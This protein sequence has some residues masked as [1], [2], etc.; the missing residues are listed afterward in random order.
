MDDIFVTGLQNIFG[1]CACIRKQKRTTGWCHYTQ[2]CLEK[3][4]L[5][6]SSEQVCDIHVHY[7]TF[8][9]VIDLF[10]AWDKENSMTCARIWTEDL[11][12]I[13][14]IYLCTELQITCPWIGSS[15]TKCSLQFIVLCINTLRTMH[16]LCF[17]IF[18]LEHQWDFLY[19][20]LFFVSTRHCST[21]LGSW[22][23]RYIQH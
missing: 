20:F 5:Q 7:F 1:F 22:M 3:C 13:E 23:C 6:W 8:S 10:L 2:K 14:L 21:C 17:V 19:N 15:V 18:P 12:I 4:L 11:V 16:Q 9:L